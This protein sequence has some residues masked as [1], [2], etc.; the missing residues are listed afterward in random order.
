MDAASPRPRGW[1]RAGDHVRGVGGGFPA[2]AGMD[3]CGACRPGR[4]GRLPRARGDGPHSIRDIG[5]RYEA[6]PRPRGWTRRARTVRADCLGFP[7]PAGM[8]PSARASA[9]ATRRLPRA[10][11]DGPA[12]GGHVRSP[13]A[14]SPRP[15]GWTR[16]VH[17]RRLESRGFPAPAGMDPSHRI[18]TRTRE[19]LP[20]ARGDGPEDEQ[21][22]LQTLTASPRP[23]GWTAVTRAKLAPEVGFPA[24]AGMDPP[25]R[26]PGRRRRR[27]P[28]ARGDGPGR[29]DARG[30]LLQASPRPRG[31]TPRRP[32]R[33]VRVVGFPAPAGM[34]P[35]GASRETDPPR[36]PRARGDGP[37]A[38]FRVASRF[39]ASPRPRGWTAQRRLQ[40]DPAGGF[41]A[42]AGMDP[43]HS[44]RR[45]RE[46]GLPRAR[47][48]GPRRKVN[49]SQ[50]ET[51][52][53]RPR[54]WTLMMASSSS[55][56]KGFP[57]PAGM[58]PC[59]LIWPL[60]PMRASP[61]P[62]G[63]T[64]GFALLTGPVGG[65]PAPA[66]MDPDRPGSP[67][68]AAGLPRARGDGP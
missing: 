44:C 2:P 51:A 38:G 17:V 34:D 23:R 25:V 52:S 60:P 55:S 7:A 64:G 49:P 40:G 59:S 58:D 28:R 1:T 45:G 39:A 47:G 8:D 4:T 33:K 13:V 36:L 29:T 54:G 68:W 18:R 31:W 50:V 41:P 12:G 46:L 30:C 61:R 48:D 43:P 5:Y 3:R 24:P 67:P 19:W 9:W 62:R 53:P 65:F 15:R 26:C 37:W 57:A 10:R 16:R 6:S 35:A 20:R 66:G 32:G 21:G 63:W 27:L 22:E 11:G 14:A 56:V 42:P